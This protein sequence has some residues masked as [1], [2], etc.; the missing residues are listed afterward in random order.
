MKSNSC[1]LSFRVFDRIGIEH[2]GAIAVGIVLLYSAVTL[3][4]YKSLGICRFHISS[5]IIYTDYQN[6]FQ[7]MIQMR[8][9]VVAFLYNNPR[10]HYILFQFSVPVLCTMDVRFFPPNNLIIG[11]RPQH[12]QFCLLYIKHSK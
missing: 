2:N 10:L 3:V 7:A 8:G 9:I 6:I 1:I 5:C 11:L 4:N 12:K